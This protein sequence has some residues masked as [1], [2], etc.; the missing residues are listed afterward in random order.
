VLSARLCLTPPSSEVHPLC[1]GIQSLNTLSH[2]HG[3]N[4]QRPLKPEINPTPCKYMITIYN[5]NIHWTHTYRHAYNDRRCRKNCS[6]LIMANACI[7]YKVFSSSPQLYMHSIYP[8]LSCEISKSLLH[9]AAQSSAS[10][11]DLPTLIN[12]NQWLSS[13]LSRTR[14]QPIYNKCLS[15]LQP[16]QRHGIHGS[17]A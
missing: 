16:A 2:P 3:M 14:S 4:P 7:F 5:C 11:Q 1:T 15:Y 10:L 6:V 12:Y 17:P 9:E 8:T 13:L